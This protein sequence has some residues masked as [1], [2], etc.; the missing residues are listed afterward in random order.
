MTVTML[1]DIGWQSISSDTDGF[2]AS[3][4]S[5]LA[6]TL[7]APRRRFVIDD[8][9][10]YSGRRRRRGSMGAFTSLVGVRK[11]TAEEY[12]ST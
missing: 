12:K 6:D 11:S 7:S 4:H 3:L 8:V 10:E 2:A 9:R 5:E 1:F